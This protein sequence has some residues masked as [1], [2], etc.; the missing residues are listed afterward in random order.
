MKFSKII[1][2]VFVL[3]SL[4]AYAQNHSTHHHHVAQESTTITMPDMTMS[5]HGMYGSYA[6]TREASG[7]SWQPQSTPLTGLMIMNS[8]TMYMLQGFANL[9]YNHQGGPRGATQTYSTSMFMFMA[10]KDLEV[11]TLGFRSMIS[12]DPQM[13]SGGYPL[14]FQTGETANGRTPLVDRQHPHN[15]IMELAA[16][17]SVPLAAKD[18][19]FIYAGLAGEPALGPP[20]FMMRWSGMDIPEAPLTHHWLDSTHITYGVVTLGYIRDVL[21]LE[22]SAF[23]GR[24]PDQSRWRMESPQLSSHSI[25][26]SY[27]PTDN[28]SLQASYGHLK[29]PEQLE[30]DVNTNRATMSAIYNLA[31]GAQNNWQTTVAWGQN[32]NHPGHT[33]NGYLL[34]S[35]V[36]FKQT[37]TFFGRLE[38]LQEDELFQ[39]PSTFTDEIFNINKLS[40]GYLYEFSTW[41][42]A[43]PG[44]GVL[45]SAYAIPSTVQTAYGQRPFSYMLFGRIAIA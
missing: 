8:G 24:E 27:N 12:M 39:P 25:R 11:G 17:Y 36:N 2:S 26:L 40:L 38:H 32:V 42:H 22:V 20:S 44:V 21:K 3:F 41:H 28:L 33:L 13:G 19:A 45:M 30:P 5:M 10:Q 4:N 37:H 7:T 9:N 16:T 18:S 29:S 43:K 34:E 1:L 14:L 23:N 15:L 35:A 6:M 31:F